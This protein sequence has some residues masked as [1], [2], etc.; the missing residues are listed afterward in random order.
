MDICNQ[1]A[2]SNWIT[3]INEISFNFIC[4]WLG[5]AAL[6]Y[7]CPMFG[8]KRGKEFCLNLLLATQIDINFSN[9]KQEE[10]KSISSTVVHHFMHI[11]HV[12]MCIQN[13]KLFVAHTDG[14]LAQPKTNSVW[15]QNN[16]A[17]LWQREV[18]AANWCNTIIMIRMTQRGRDGGE[19]RVIQLKSH[20][21]FIQGQA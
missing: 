16:N 4:S 8:I 6:P 17:K 7:N 21:T 15:I 11:H 10:R 9:E 1:L 20:K 13:I 18:C 2:S 12:W 19:G 14:W 5:C 3:T